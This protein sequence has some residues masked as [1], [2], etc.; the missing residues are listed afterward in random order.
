MKRRRAASGANPLPA[1]ACWGEEPEMGDFRA[2]T[3]SGLPAGWQE[4]TTAV[5]GAKLY[6]I[7]PENGGDAHWQVEITVDQKVSRRRCATE[8]MARAWL[9]GW[10]EPACALRVLDAEDRNRGLRASFLRGT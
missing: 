2:G 3:S 7:A 10:H 9:A 4:L 6:R 1:T 5:S 8:L